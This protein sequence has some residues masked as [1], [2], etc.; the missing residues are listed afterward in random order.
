V[1]EG[2]LQKQVTGKWQPGK[3]GRAAGHA[4][5][6]VASLGLRCGVGEGGCRGRGSL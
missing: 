5:E 2:G 6:Q 4:T 1:G 3:E